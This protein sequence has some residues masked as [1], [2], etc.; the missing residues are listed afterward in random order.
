[1]KTA[2]L[3]TPA[4]SWQSTSGPRIDCR[5]HLCCSSEGCAKPHSTMARGSSGFRRKSRKPD[6]WRAV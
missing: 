3:P 4:L 6:A 1:M 2:I 5:I